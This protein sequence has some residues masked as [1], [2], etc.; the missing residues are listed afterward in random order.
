MEQT[1]L[2]VARW[3]DMWMYHVPVWWAWYFHGDL[4]WLG[5]GL[6][7]FAALAGFGLGYIIFRRTTRV[8]RSNINRHHTPPS[9]NDG[10][11]HSHSTE[12]GGT[13]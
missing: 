9:S 2:A 13:I 5:A 1:F 7:A 10:S 8:S 6:H 4:S 11:C 3:V 12:K